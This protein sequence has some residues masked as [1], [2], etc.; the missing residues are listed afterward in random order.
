MINEIN[1]VIIAR[2]EQINQETIG[3]ILFSEKWVEKLVKYTESDYYRSSDDVAIFV[4]ADTSSRKICLKLLSE[5]SGAVPVNLFKTSV[6]PKKLLRILIDL[7]MMHK[8]PPPP[9]TNL[10]SCVETNQKEIN[11]INKMIVKTV[12]VMTLNT[13]TILWFILRIRPV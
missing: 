8:L 7:I 2:D 10:F 13:F 12:H 11:T 9:L 5:K 1:Q 6:L 4:K 3:E